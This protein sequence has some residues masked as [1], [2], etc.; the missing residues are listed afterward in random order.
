MKFF[1]VIFFFITPVANCQ[2]NGTDFAFE[3]ISRSVTEI[4]NT[5]EKLKKHSKKEVEDLRFSKELASKINTTL[6]GKTKSILISKETA[7]NKKNDTIN[8]I[9]Y[10][11]ILIK[12]TDIKELQEKSNFGIKRISLYKWPISCS[13]FFNLDKI[14]CVCENSF[15]SKVLQD[16]NFTKSIIEST[17]LRLKTLVLKK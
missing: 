6:Y 4:L 5:N 15:T 13:S 17:E 8:Y 16:D 14:T 10:D 12:G 1:I 11:F 9:V 3:V 7:T 2:A